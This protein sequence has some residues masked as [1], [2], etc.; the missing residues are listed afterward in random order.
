LIPFIALLG[1]KIK[2]S[3]ITDHTLTNIY[4]CE[5]F[6]DIKFEVDKENKIIEAKRR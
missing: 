5:Q 2:V 6:L 3:E 4:V 1:G